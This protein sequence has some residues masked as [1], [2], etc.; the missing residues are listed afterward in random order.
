MVGALTG[1]V[2][3]QDDAALIKDVVTKLNSS[4]AVRGTDD[5][6]SYKVLFDAYL[7]LT[8]PPFEIGPDFNLSTI[9]PKMSTW[10]AVSGWAESNA[11]MAQA[12][13]KC[14][15][16]TLL[17]L[18]YGRD[19]VDATYAKAD[20]VADV[21]AG[22]SLR[23]VQFPYLNAIDTIQAFT[24]AEMYRLLEAGQMQQAI[25]LGV[26]NCFV[27]RQICDRDFLTEKLRAIELLSSAL[28]N[29]RDM[30]YT[31]QDKFEAGQLSAVAMKEMPFLRPDR[32]RLFMPEADRILAEALI[33]D[34]FN[35]RNGE[36]DPDKFTVTFA[37]IQSKDAPL[38]R[39]GAAKRWRA[40]AAI[41]G[42]LDA[43]L[44]RL[45]LIYDDWWRRW[46]IDA[47]DSILAIPTQLDRTNPIRYAA[48]I[49][50]IENVEVLFE[51]R[52]RL[53][54][55]VN[56]TALAAGL[57]GYRKTFGV[58]PDKTEKTFGQSAR[59]ISDSDPYDKEL[60]PLKYRLLD[61]RQ[62][63]DTP[64]G[65]LWIEAGEGLL[66]SQGQDHEDQRVV[67]HTDDGAAGDIMIWP[68]VKAL[69][70]AQGLIQ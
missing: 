40:I 53:I 62:A 50:S 4:E 66:W 49:Y 57:C 27:L 9:H 31:Y 33:K 47:Y 39:F 41:H 30:L 67:Q 15:D 13:L 61:Q 37:E 68:P 54:A 24:T 16:K 29:L 2:H 23:N 51:I 14:K 3:A 56:G 11:P 59:K 7:Q 18:P 38:T 36:A 44:E 55:E 22:G 17:G 8:K 28:S 35:A 43:S 34:V 69:Q 46:R 63:V 52:N 48:V 10:S 60:L 42:S 58:Y 45:K 1:A 64:A 19:A 65:R 25:D 26:A 12:I 20:L 70:R 6:K 5:I 32:G 21:G